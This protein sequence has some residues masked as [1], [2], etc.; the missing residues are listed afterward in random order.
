V[1]NKLLSLL[2]ICRKAGKLV[3]GFDAVSESVKQGT[4]KLV[5]VS[6]DISPKTKKEIEFI[7]SKTNTKVITA[8]VTMSGIEQKTGKRAGVLAILDDGLAKAVNE[9]AV[10]AGEEEYYDRKIQGA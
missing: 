6:C 9:A 7:S 8:P 2:G 1:K 5:L 3:H 10:R 4:A